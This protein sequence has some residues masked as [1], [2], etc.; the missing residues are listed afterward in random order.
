MPNNLAGLYRAIGRYAAAEPFVRRAVAILE[1]S[2][3]ADHPTQTRVRKKESM[4]NRGALAGE[5]R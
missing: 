4:R 3:P 5:R 2:L 1:K